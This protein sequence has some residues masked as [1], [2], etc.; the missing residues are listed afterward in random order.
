MLSNI[1]LDELDKELERRGHSFS[2]YADDGQI[3]VKSRRAGIRVYDSIKKFLETR[4]KLK[5]NE[6]KSAVAL[7]SERV[8]LS[9]RINT[10]GDL[11]LPSKTLDR[12]K[13]KVRNISKRNRSN[14]L[15]NVIAKLNTYLPGWLQYFKLAKYKSY[16][17]DLDAWIRRKLRCYRMKQR[18]GGKALSKF[19]ISLGIPEKEARKMG[20]SGKGWWRLSRTPAAHRGMDLA[21]FRGQGLYSL[22]ENWDRLVKL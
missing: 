4:M 19:L 8:F 10:D 5:V 18:K 1:V 20:S 6:T 21:W 16:F 7:V 2:R 11:T 15:E 14:S 12:I 22:E 9:Y 13:D 17:R 3:Y